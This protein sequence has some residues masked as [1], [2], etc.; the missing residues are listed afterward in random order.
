MPKI[1]FT[2]IMVDDMGK[3]LEFYA[4]KLGFEVI[5]RDHYPDFVLLKHDY[6]IALHQVRQGAVVDYPNQASVVLGIAVDDLSETIQR[7]SQQGVDF[8]HTS[9]QKFLA[10]WYAALRDPAGNVHELI[11]LQSASPLVSP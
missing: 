5:K 1:C 2:T 11:Q 6:P 9:P 8:I 3:A 7:L 4:D 10:G